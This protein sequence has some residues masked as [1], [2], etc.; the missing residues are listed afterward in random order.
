MPKINRGRRHFV[1]QSIE[2]IKRIWTDLGFR[3]MEGSI[4]HTAF[5][6][7]DSLFIPQDHPARQMQDTFYLKNP[8]FGKLPPIYKKV[9][10]VH[11]NG[12]DTGSTGWQNIWSEDIARELM[13][14]THTTVLTAQT[15]AKVKKE[16]LPVKFFS[17]GKVFRNESLDW[18]HLFEFHQVEGFVLDE[19]IN[20]RGLLGYL[21]E[22][23]GKM[24]FKD[25]RIRPAHFPYTEPSAEIEVLN[26][27]KNEWIELGG[28]GVLR[29]E[30][31]KTLLGIDCP[32]IAWGFGLERIITAYYGITDLR[33]I[34]KN[35]LKQLR[36]M[37]EW[38]L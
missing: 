9:K 7:M 2:Y 12:G 27:I 22:F 5:W 32:A 24:G 3:E 16:D 4:V 31:V 10:E 18:K 28:C 37:K 11:E 30:V 23:F 36:E 34:F 14:R 25:V 35:D 13:L 6:D 38:M 21:K 29:P 15:I 8:K 20:F 19:D 26:P 1:R 33:E 17:V